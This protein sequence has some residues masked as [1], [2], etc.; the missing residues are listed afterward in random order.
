MK[1]LISSVKV[2]KK[3]LEEPV[4]IRNAAVDHFNSCFKE[5]CMVR[6]T[7]N[8]ADQKKKKNNIEWEVQ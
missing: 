2:N 1:N 6:I 8:G 3:I 5:E 4:L 7:L